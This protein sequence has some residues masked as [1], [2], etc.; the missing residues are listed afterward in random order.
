MVWIC[1][2][3]SIDNI[4]M[5]LLYGP[6]LERCLHRAKAFSASRTALPAGWLRVHKKLGGDTD[7]TGDPN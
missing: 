7:G 6:M 4:E 3:N 1:A 2:G 5:V